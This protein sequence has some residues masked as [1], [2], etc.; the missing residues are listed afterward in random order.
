MT[1]VVPKW[2]PSSMDESFEKLLRALGIDMSVDKLK[3]E[4]GRLEQ[5]PI[6]YLIRVLKKDYD[7]VAK[8]FSE[9][10]GIPYSDKKAVKE[11]HQA[12][13]VYDDGSIGIWNPY[14]YTY[15][16]KEFPEATVYVVPYYIFEEK[17]TGNVEGM[18]GKFLDIVQSARKVG[19]TDIHFEAKEIGLILKFRIIGELYR[20]DV[21]PL[22]EGRRL[23]KAIKQMAAVTTSNF[24]TEEWR[25]RQ[26][27]RI[28]I[29]EMK[30]DLRLAFTPSLIDGMQ[31]LVIRLLSKSALRPKGI[32]DLMALGY[33]R[34][35]ATVLHESVKA[36]TGLI[37]MSGATGS[38]KS[39]TINTLLGLIPETR[40]IRSVEDPVEYVLENAVQH[41]TMKVEKEK[42]VINMDYLE[43]LRAF[44]RQ[45]PDIIFIG[46][47][48]KIPELTEGLLYA[49]ETGHLTIT[50]LHS[51]RVV[52]VPNLLIKQYGLSPEDLANNCNLIINQ[53]LVKTVCPHCAVKRT[54]TEEDLDGIA[55][56]K[57]ADKSKLEGL[58]G[59]EGVF[60]NPEGCEHCRVYN[61]ITG[62]VVSAGYKGR[63]AIYEYL[64]FTPEVRELVLK[65]TSSLEIEKR[66]IEESG[67]SI[68]LKGDKGKDRTGITFVDVVCQKVE[69]GQISVHDGIKSL[70]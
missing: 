3:A 48:R 38:G 47:W 23:L 27:A 19:A 14:Y 2:I 4:A 33:S 66:L 13:V 9:L 61:P 54:I 11:R 65:T 37:I 57:F 53:R 32:E 21:F 36:K 26:D 41:Q 18:R 39:R 24:D 34:E 29:K 59:K 63:T 12:F 15:V 68:R 62:E 25:E 55:K 1:A 46:E 60:P 35:D 45:D 43:Y 70:M 42:K 8:A 17:E 28:E 20:I 31:N 51:S 5:K 64:V 10:S 58:V 67:N 22:D 6:E 69:N 50:T 52:N 30:L 16:K 56:L 40:N 44:M 7:E 49:A